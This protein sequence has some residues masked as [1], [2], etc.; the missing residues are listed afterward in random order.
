MSDASWGV[1]KLLWVVDGA[2]G[3]PDELRFEG[4][5]GPE[6]V[7]PDDGRGNPWRDY[8]SF[9]RLRAQGC[10]A[11]QIDTRTRSFTVAFGA[12]GPSSPRSTLTP[13]PSAAWRQSGRR[14]W[15]RRLPSIPLWTQ[16]GLPGNW[17][18]ST[19]LWVRLPPRGVLP[20][21]SNGT[22]PLATQFPWWRQDAGQLSIA[23][24]RLDCPSDLGFQPPAWSGPR[25]DAGEWPVRSPDGL[26]RSS[27]GCPRL[28]EAT[29]TDSASAAACWAASLSVRSA[30]RAWRTSSRSSCAVCRSCSRGIRAS[31]LLCSLRWCSSSAE[32]APPTSDSPPAADRHSVINLLIGSHC[33]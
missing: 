19:A 1:A 31:C 4:S 16:R 25:K 5:R 29:T 8:S 2:L 23:A 14:R 30:A 21:Q 27:P 13:G 9:T 22:D 7:L 10:Y 6:L 28:A 24:Q 3:G 20:V 32:E 12:V 15:C 33:T 17:Y 18:R 11:Y 26:C